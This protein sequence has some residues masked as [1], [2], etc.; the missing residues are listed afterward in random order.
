M[1][2]LLCLLL[3]ATSLLA[4]DNTVSKP[5]AEG[6]WILLFD[7]E[8]L[9]GLVQEGGSHWQISDG[10]LMP[11][12]GGGY[13][14]ANSAFSDFDLKLEYR[15]SGADPDCSL[16]LRAAPDSDPKDASYQ[17][18]IGDTNS[19]WPVGSIVGHFK[20]DESHPALN[21]WHALDATLTADHF[22]ITLDGK[23]MVDE[24]DGRG[25]AGYIELGCSRTGKTQFRNIKLRPLGAKDLFNG[26]DLSGWKAV[27]P[28]PPK[29]G[30]LKKLTGGGK[31]K[32]AEWSAMA[33][34]IHGEKGVGQLES[35]A[36]YDDFVL[37][38]A[39][40]VNARD[41]KEH[42]KSAVF[43]RGDPGQLFSG[44]EVQV[45]N[46]YKNG[47]RSQPVAF[48]TGGLKD[49]E[50][51]RKELADDNQFFTE[52]IAARGRHIQI[53]VDGYPVCDY[54][55]ARAE[56]TPTEKGARS[57]GAISLQ[58][59]DEKANLD[60]RNISIT[61]LPKTLG[62]GAPPPVVAAAP[63]PAPSAPVINFPAPKE[64]PNKPKVQALMAQVL[65]TNDPEEQVRL[66]TQ[67]LL[68]D[69]EN[70]VA[71][72][73]RQQAK[74]KIDE[75]NAKKQQEEQQKVE[76]TSTQNEKD[77]QGADAKQK[78]EAAFIAGDLATAKTQIATAEKLLQNDPEVEALRSRIDVASKARERV[79][80]FWTAAG[81]LAI[82]GL[83][84][85]LFVMGRNKDAYLEVIQGMD[86]GKRYNLDQEV[87]HIGAIAQDGGNKNE[88]VV[89]DM[90]RMISRFHCEIHKRN[91]KFFLIDL[92]SANGT[93]V[94]RQTAKAGK[95][96]RLK[97]GARVELGGTCAM[98]LGWERRK[99][100]KA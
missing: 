8:T 29:K 80:Y 50:V 6:G 94:D 75:A 54:Q 21:Q 20:A 43:V 46:D 57:V 41:K 72:N 22:V 24:K 53:W 65:Q 99:K 32:E 23:I 88:I 18:Q 47:D 68:L 14:R 28:T 58:S 86:K 66:Y 13:L 97:T 92:G 60:F 63:P 93:T 37:Q 34:V 48:G 17:V 45:M 64:D 69:P 12:G 55:D 15:T 70:Q 42:P 87:I 51:A 78:A 44:Y 1:K 5:E 81:I 11:V 79:K 74:Q 95:P 19:Q 82:V 16:F 4:K 62:K 89:R 98:R 31:V 73:G 35:A 36:T 76:V 77:T 96:I 83:V 100:A 26:T 59:P 3:V 90:E 2:K 61:Q 67:I 84:T 33:G 56:G 49:L 52:T 71:F 91:G 39:I 7:G 85:T 40:R 9:F 30:M 27:G 25:K 10:S 38:L